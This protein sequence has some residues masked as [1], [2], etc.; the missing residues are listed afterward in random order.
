MY[1]IS[2]KAEE[3]DEPDEDEEATS[4][5]KFQILSDFEPC[6]NSLEQWEIDEMNKF[7]IHP[8]SGPIYITYSLFGLVKYLHPHAS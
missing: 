4:H 5:A 3:E 6:S 2:W 7:I 8:P 1:T